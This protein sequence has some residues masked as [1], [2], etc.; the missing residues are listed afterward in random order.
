MLKWWRLSCR[1]KHTRTHTHT[2]TS[3]RTLPHTHSL[4]PSHIHTHTQ[5]L[6]Y[7]HVCM[8]V[9]CSDIGDRCVVA[10]T[11]TRTHTH[12]HLNAH[13]LPRSLPPSL[14]YTDIGDRCVVA[15]SS[16][17]AA[18]AVFASTQW[19]HMSFRVQIW[20]AGTYTY[21]YMGMYGC[22]NICGQTWIYYTTCS[23][24]PHVAPSFEVLVRVYVY[25]WIR[26]GVYMC[27]NKNKQKKHTTCWTMPHVAQNADLN[28]WYIYAYVHGTVRMGVY[29]CIKPLTCYPTHTCIKQRKHITTRSTTL[30]GASDS[31][32]KWWYICM[33]VLIHG[34]VWVIIYVHFLV[35]SFKKS[36]LLIVQYK[37]KTSCGEDQMLQDLILPTG[38]CGTGFIPQNGWVVDFRWFSLGQHDQAEMF[39]TLR[40]QLP[41]GKWEGKDLQYFCMMYR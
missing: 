35:A 23:M 16:A 6:S 17:A 14:S 1:R 7:T 20:S 22:V 18:G 11:H 40:Y 34:Y 10:N 31:D 25:T 30:H 32:L 36:I 37:C 38:L 21:I 27:V 28:C 19:C 26:M 24:M 8:C 9:F 41:K 39:C 29:I 5:S 12:T 13:S 15:K 4:S 3:M 2:H 33:N